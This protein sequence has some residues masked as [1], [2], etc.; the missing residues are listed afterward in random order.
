MEAYRAALCEYTA[1]KADIADGQPFLLDTIAAMAR[2]ANVPNHTL[3]LHCNMSTENT[4]NGQTNSAML[5]R[6][7]STLN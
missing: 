7:G 1:T 5:T 2:Q 3:P 6:R 4:T